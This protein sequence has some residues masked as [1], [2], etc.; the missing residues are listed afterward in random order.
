MQT[1]RH[2]ENGLLLRISH[3]GNQKPLFGGIRMVFILF[4]VVLFL[5]P[6]SVDFQKDIPDRNLISL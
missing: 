1:F 2:F 6:I 3:D 5:F 4:A